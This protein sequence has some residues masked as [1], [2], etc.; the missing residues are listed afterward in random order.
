M[1]GGNNVWG[2]PQSQASKHSRSHRNQHELSQT[3]LATQ[4]PTPGQN[5]GAEI[6]THLG[7]TASS[8]TGVAVIHP[9]GSGDLDHDL[10]W[11]CWPLLLQRVQTTHPIITVDPFTG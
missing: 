9:R 11:R 2:H 3:R 6:P 4:I 10:S 5:P 1:E 8:E 7:T